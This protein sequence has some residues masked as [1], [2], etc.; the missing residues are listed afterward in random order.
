MRSFKLLAIP[1]VVIGLLSGCRQEISR[2]RVA[3]LKMSIPIEIGL[4]DEISC[5]IGP[6]S[7]FPGGHDVWISSKNQHFRHIIERFGN[8][9]NVLLF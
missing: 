1:L 2:P 9:C 5:G 8:N 6:A 7:E 4:D 3:V